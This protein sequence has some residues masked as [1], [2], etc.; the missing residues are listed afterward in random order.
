MNK[1]QIMQQIA[2]KK[3]EERFK[4]QQEDLIEFIKLYF[5]RERP[6]GIKKFHVSNFHLIIA[7]RLHRLMK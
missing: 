4:P 7:D 3:L 2:I 6:K 1:E 5:E